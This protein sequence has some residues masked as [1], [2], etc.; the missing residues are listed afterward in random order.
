MHGGGSILGILLAR[1]KRF[2][3]RDDEDA[4]E[5]ETAPAKRRRTWARTLLLVPLLIALF[6]ISI[7]EL[8]HPAAGKAGRRTGIIAALEDP[9]ALFAERSP[10]ERGAGPLLSTKPGGPAERV[11]SGVRDRDPAAGAPPAVAPITPDDIAALGN[12][13]PGDG[14]LPGG[15]DA[16][17]QALGNASPFFAPFTPAGFGDPGDP[18]IVRSPTP[19]GDGPP[20]FPP[21]P[22]GGV[23]AVPEPATWAMLILGFFGIGAALRRRRE[24]RSGNTCRAP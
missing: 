14:G 2:V 19:P 6:F 5:S 4:P 8:G 16:P 21:P 24:P 15:G 20:G 13:V 3:G 22:L 18:G 23:T 11:L 17:G 9:L 12:G 7:A 10:G 1:V